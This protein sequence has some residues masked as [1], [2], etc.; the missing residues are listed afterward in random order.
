MGTSE[1]KCANLVQPSFGVNRYYRQCALSGMFVCT[2]FG[3][4]IPASFGFFFYPLQCAESFLNQDPVYHFAAQKL[5]LS[6]EACT[7]SFWY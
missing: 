5:G 4:V 7:Y 6:F 2:S 3:T 1:F